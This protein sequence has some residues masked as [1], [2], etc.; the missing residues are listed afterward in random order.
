MPDTL[1]QEITN[2]LN[3]TV[4]RALRRLTVEA[5]SAHDAAEALTHD[6]S[7]KGRRAMRLARR[8]IRHHPGAAI[9]FGAALGGLATFLLTRRS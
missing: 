8:E 9:A 6:A 7:A 2:D 3:D 5:R 1:V 4:K